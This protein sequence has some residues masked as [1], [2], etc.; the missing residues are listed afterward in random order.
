MPESC[1]AEPG[2]ARLAPVHLPQQA[3]EQAIRRGS[4]LVARF[5]PCDFVGTSLAGAEELVRNTMSTVA[6]NGVR[7]AFYFL[8]A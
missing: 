3:A 1:Q 2:R 7:N 4:S 6:L 5:F 8:L